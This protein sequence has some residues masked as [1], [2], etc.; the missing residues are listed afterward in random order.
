MAITVTEHR[1]RVARAD[2]NSGEEGPVAV[3]VEELVPGLHEDVPP[4]SESSNYLEDLVRAGNK[5]RLTFVQTA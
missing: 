4:A 5:A 1:C 2:P 3:P